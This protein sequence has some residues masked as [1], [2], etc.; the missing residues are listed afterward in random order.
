MVGGA[1]ASSLPVLAGCG[2]GIAAAA[3][4]PSPLGSDVG[5]AA[6][7][8]PTP[9][10]NGVASAAAVPLPPPAAFSAGCGAEGSAAAALV[11]VPSPA[12]GCFAGTTTGGSAVTFGRG[13][14]GALVSTDRHSSG[15][16]VWSVTAVTCS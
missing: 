1:A 11:V 7:L 15:A 14:A 10:G 9:S 6:P 16:P 2:V 5:S 4:L 8:P 13:A 3:L 12:V